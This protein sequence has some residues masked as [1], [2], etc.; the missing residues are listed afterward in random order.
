MARFV[1]QESEVFS[2]TIKADPPFVAR[3]FEASFRQLRV[4]VCPIQKQKRK[5]I[6]TN[7]YAERGLF[8]LAVIV[9]EIVADSHIFSPRTKT[10]PIS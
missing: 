6:Q 9:K 5:Q 10:F 3:L 4:V 2:V 1:F 7:S 8:V